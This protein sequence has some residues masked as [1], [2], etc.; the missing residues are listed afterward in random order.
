[1]SNKDTKKSSRQPAR[2][3][4]IR[5]S[6]SI[7]TGDKKPPAIELAQPRRAAAKKG[8]AKK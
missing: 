4:F 1:M 7:K 5:N 3:G 2:I 6:G 8:G